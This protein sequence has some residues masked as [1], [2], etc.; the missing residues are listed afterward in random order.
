MFLRTRCG[1]LCA[2]TLQLAYQK[3][4][5]DLT[6]ELHLDLCLYPVLKFLLEVDLE[7]SNAGT[8]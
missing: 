3:M 8:T 2:A 1:M 4:K 5:M 7:P 6:L